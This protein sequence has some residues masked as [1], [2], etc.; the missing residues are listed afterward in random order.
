M[1]ART[2]A[3][4][5]PDKPCIVMVDPDQS[6]TYA[7]FEA[8]ANRLA[9]LLE[10]HGLRPGD[11][12]AIFMEN[13]ISYHEI[14]AAGERSGLYYT[15]ISSQLTADE[16]GYILRDCTAKVLV[17]SVMLL[18]IAR[19]AVAQAPGSRADCSALAQLGAPRQRGEQ[20]HVA[21]LE[22]RSHHE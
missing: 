4:K 21:E 19:D 2:H 16:V 14:C 1:Y 10:S 8:R 13:H 12:Y 15:P 6:V 3:E 20:R 18:P 5:H 7:E 9:H 22:G 11:H 17:T